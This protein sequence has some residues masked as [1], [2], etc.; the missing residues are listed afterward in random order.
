MIKNNKVLG[1]T[2]IN[3]GIKISVIIPCYNGEEVLSL[4][5]EKTK[6]LSNEWNYRGDCGSVELLFADDGSRD[7]AAELLAE[8]TNAN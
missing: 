8:A 4:T 2:K 1:K 7:R 6:K 5:P 3:D